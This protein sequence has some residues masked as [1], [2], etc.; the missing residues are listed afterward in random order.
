MECMYIGDGGGEEEG[1]VFR[2]YQNNSFVVGSGQTIIE[3]QNSNT[4][5]VR[6]EMSCR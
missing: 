4:M 2:I 5:K 3:A 6:A 1:G